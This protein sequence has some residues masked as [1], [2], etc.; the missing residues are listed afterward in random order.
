[1]RNGSI[2]VSPTQ[3]K[4]KAGAWPWSPTTLPSASTIWAYPVTRISARS[5]PGTS[6]MTSAIDASIRSPT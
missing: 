5:T 1:M 2:E 6:R 4:P 3:L